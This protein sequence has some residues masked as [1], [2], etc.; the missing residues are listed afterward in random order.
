MLL[1]WTLQIISLFLWIFV[2]FVLSF[3]SKD[4]APE[5]IG[6]GNAGFCNI[7]KYNCMT[8]RVFGQGFKE[9]PSTKCEVTKLQVC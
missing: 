3:L 1:I 9:L 5:I 8:V 7:R 6:L 4:K 2:H